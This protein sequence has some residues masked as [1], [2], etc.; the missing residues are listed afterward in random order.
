RAGQR[1]RADAA[2]LLQPGEGALALRPPGINRTRRSARNARPPRFWAAWLGS[3]ADFH[4]PASGP[5]SPFL[6][7]GNSRGPPLN[8]SGTSG[9][10]EGCVGLGKA[11]A[12]RE[13]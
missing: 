2:V 9:K 8:Y 7:Y 5:G 11:A 13:R 4:G 6:R 10:E 3:C 1:R 12:R